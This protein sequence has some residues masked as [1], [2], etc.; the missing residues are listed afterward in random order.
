S[1]RGATSSERLWGNHSLAQQAIDQETEDAATRELIRTSLRETFFVEAGAGTG[2]T[3]ALVE[4]VVALVLGGHEIDRIVA[5]TFTEKAA[6]E[7][8]DRIR[9]GLEAAKK[10][11]AESEATIEEALKSLDRAQISTIHAFCHSV[12][13]S[14]A[15]E[16][17]IDPS[18]R[19]QDEVMADRRFR[20]RWRIYLEDL[21]ED[22]EGKL[23]AAAESI[24]MRSAVSSQPAWGGKEI[25]ERVRRVA[26]DIACRLNET[27]H[28]CRSEALAAVVPVV[29]RFVVEDAYRRAREGALT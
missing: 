24:G 2:K 21:A 5:I 19:V 22:R 18:F 27:L 28:A 11:R 6:A 8:R 16:A 3:S 17:G 10:D 1:I 20:E 29:V 15:A 23:A 13:Y 4:R 7:L 12:L 25:I 14:Y 26:S 9:A